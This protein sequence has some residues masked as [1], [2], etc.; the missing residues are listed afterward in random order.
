MNRTETMRFLAVRMIAGLAGDWNTGATR[1][2]SDVTWRAEEAAGFIM[3]KAGAGR[4]DICATKDRVEDRK[5][6]KNN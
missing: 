3:E 4:L 2:I 1:S 5:A 6:P